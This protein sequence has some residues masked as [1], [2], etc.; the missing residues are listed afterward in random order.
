MSLDIKSAKG[1]FRFCPLFLILMFPLI[2]CGSHH[3]PAAVLPPPSPQTGSIGV[4]KVA[5]NHKYQ[6]EAVF[7]GEG[8]EVGDRIEKVITS[9][10][11]RSKVTG[12]SVKYSRE[13][14]PAPED[15]DAYF[16]DVWSPDDEWLVL[17]LKR[18]FGFCIIRA[19]DALDSIEKQRCADILFVR[20]GPTTNEG[21]WHDFERWDGDEAFV[22]KAG[23]YGDSTRL[24]Y[25]IQSSRLTALDP[26]A[27]PR[28]IEGWNDK[29]KVAIGS[30]N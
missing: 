10:T 17:P 7:S 26:N 20:I 23:L 16:T 22:F 28:T 4:I 14:G 1:T 3:R 13:D 11:I 27:I 12:R 25:D 18:F 8:L 15:S 5:E 2:S 21:L 24:R 29:G 30:N 9:V 6:L 19:R